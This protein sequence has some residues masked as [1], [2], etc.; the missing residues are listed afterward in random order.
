MPKNYTSTNKAAG[1]YDKSDFKYDKERDIYVCPADQ[2]LKFRGE[3]LDRGVKVDSY[4]TSHTVCA[5]CPLKTK[6]TTGKERRVRRREHDDLLESMEEELNRKSDAMVIRAQTVEHPFGTIKTWMGRQH[7]L[8][9]R[10]PNVRTEMSL[11]VLAYNMKRV[12]SI[13]GVSTMIEVL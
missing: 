4:Y 6:C 8:M 5:A 9:K 1:L 12:M 10:L 3:S 11:H 7:F 2:V 13:L